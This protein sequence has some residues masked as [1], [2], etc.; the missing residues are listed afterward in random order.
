M[1]VEL[2][3]PTA[4]ERCPHGRLEGVRKR[5]RSR[6]APGF[7]R[8]MRELVPKEE[9]VPDCGGGHPTIEAAYASLN[10]VSCK[11]SGVRSRALRPPH[12]GTTGSAIDS[13]PAAVSR[14]AVD[15]RSVTSTARRTGPD[16]RRP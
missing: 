1:R 14:P 13:P 3:D 2:P 8:E 7:G 15:S 9:V 11:P 6:F 16:T 4:G 5:R 12:G 10:S